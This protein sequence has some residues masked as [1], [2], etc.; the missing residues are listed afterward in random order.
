[1][2]WQDCFPFEPEDWPFGPTGYQQRVTYC[3]RKSKHWK[4]GTPAGTWWSKSSHG[5]ARRVGP[6]PLAAQGKNLRKKWR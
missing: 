1:M 4:P 3:V 6:V 2:A 5:K